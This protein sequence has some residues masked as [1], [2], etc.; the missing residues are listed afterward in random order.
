M[1]QTKL[2]KKGFATVIMF[3]MFVFALPPIY[4][5]RSVVIFSFCV[6]FATY[7][8]KYNWGMIRL[9]TR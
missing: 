9:L 8:K 2:I 7:G 3:F 4:Y 6:Y 1:K 5:E